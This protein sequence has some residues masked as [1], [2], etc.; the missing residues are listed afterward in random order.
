MDI[1]KTNFG[2]VAFYA[3]NLYLVL[4]VI[5]FDGNIFEILFIYFSETFIFMILSI[6]KIFFLKISL[7]SKIK[8]TLT[9]SFGL[10]I[11]IGFEAAVI[12]LFYM[13]EIEIQNPDAELF[14]NLKM[15]FN[16]SYFLGLMFFTV[17][18]VYYFVYDFLKKEKYIEQSIIQMIKTPF[19]RLWILLIT[20]F[21][22]IATFKYINSIF[23]LIS[24]IMLRTWLDNPYRKRK[25]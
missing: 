20:V 2:K 4:S 21:V 9:Y 24:F 10:L 6:V 8:N 12:L 19:L 5:F 25:S 16:L 18:H 13:R 14:E 7:N 15:I 17:S 23:V 22:G 3:A 1:K 11:F